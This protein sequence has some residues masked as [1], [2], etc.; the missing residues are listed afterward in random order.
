MLICLKSFLVCMSY[1][2]QHNEKVILTL[3]CSVIHWQAEV[4]VFKGITNKCLGYVKKKL[5]K[6]NNRVIAI[7]FYLGWIG[8][9]LTS[10]IIQYRILCWSILPKSIPLHLD[11]SPR[12]DICHH[13]GMS[14][15]DFGDLVK[16]TNGTQLACAQE[17][18]VVIWFF[19]IHREKLG[20]GI[21]DL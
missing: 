13:C 20:T 19:L 4:Q 5:L 18:W 15:S 21:I 11:F 3:V 2:K 1:S 17:W 12:L 6:I 9:V 7:T 8:I 16:V 10:R 14:I